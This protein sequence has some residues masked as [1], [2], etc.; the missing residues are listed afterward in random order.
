MENKSD[1][2]MTAAEAVDREY[3]HHF[4][5]NTALD[6]GTVHGIIARTCVPKDR[7]QQ[8]MMDGHRWKLAIAAL[9]LDGKL[10]HIRGSEVEAMAQQLSQEFIELTREVVELRNKTKA[11]AAELSSLR[12]FKSSVDEALNSGDGTYRP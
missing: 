3:R 4:T 8:V 2:I 1:G 10:E 9:Y 11:D 7:Y 5:S 12:A 6:V